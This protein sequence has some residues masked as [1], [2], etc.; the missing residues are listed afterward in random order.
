MNPLTGTPC[1]APRC[2]KFHYTTPRLFLTARS[3]FYWQKR[4]IGLTSFQKKIKYPE[5]A[6]QAGDSSMDCPLFVW[7]FGV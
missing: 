5:I 6:R 7:C 4:R 2:G 1:D 3:D